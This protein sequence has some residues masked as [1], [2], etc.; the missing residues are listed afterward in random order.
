[1]SRSA[2]KSRTAIVMWRGSRYEI[3]VARCNRAMVHLQVE[4]V[5]DSLEDLAKLAGVSRS[6]TS[7]F[8][9]GKGGGPA[10]VRVILRVLRLEFATVVSPLDEQ[11]DAA[12]A[13]SNG[14]RAEAGAETVSTRAVQ[15]PAAFVERA[16]EGHVSEHRLET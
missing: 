11:A 1:V 10:T 7:R 12:Q 15:G 6:T 3:D 5:L 13:G 2:P 16:P 4:G 9:S 8:M 14:T